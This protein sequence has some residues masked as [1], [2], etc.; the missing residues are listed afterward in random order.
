MHLTEDP[1]DLRTR[2][3]GEAALGAIVD[4]FYLR[5]TGDAL[6]APVFAR[7]DLPALRLHQQQ[8]LN[9]V[10]DAPTEPTAAH[11]RTAHQDLQITPRQFAALVQH[12]QA[13]LRDAGVPDAVMTELIQTVEQYA[14]DV[15][16]R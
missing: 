6:V 9:T 15:I 4:N 8:F 10:I 1:P 5:V 14:D 16:G 7:V 2:L 13:A 11:L 3:G 12:L